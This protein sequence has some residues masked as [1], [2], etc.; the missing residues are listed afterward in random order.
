[1]SERRIDPELICQLRQFRAATPQAVATDLTMF[2]RI[3][4]L[5]HEMA[6]VRAR[7]AVDLIVRNLAHESGLA[8]GS[9]P[10]EQIIHDLAK[11]QRLP[12]VIERHC[13]IVKDFGNLAAHGGESSDEYDSGVSLSSAEANLCAEA[14]SAVLRW[15]I[16]RVAPTLTEA[17][18]HAKLR[19]CCFKR[20]R[21]RCSSTRSDWKICR[22]VIMSC[23][24]WLVFRKMP[25]LGYIHLL[26]DSAE[27]VG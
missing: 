15:Y 7:R 10:L 26:V 19:G 17:R 16:S 4:E 18:R 25:S 14:T 12:P 24:A 21:L 6:I 3:V 2:N 27:G 1:M 20:A 11:A 23:E 5:D 9:R 8:S 13:R 22:P